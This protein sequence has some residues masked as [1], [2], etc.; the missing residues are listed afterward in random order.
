M[1]DWD[2]H[3]DYL[4][5]CHKVARVLGVTAVDATIGQGFVFT[6]GRISDAVA[7]RISDAVLQKIEQ[8]IIA[9]NREA[10]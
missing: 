2:E 7:G 9:A 5:R 10:A 8:L 4:E 6:A 3:Y 1:S